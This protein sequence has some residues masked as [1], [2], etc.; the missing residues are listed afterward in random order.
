MPQPEP[1]GLRSRANHSGRVQT[2][3]SLGTASPPP[4]APCSAYGTYILFLISLAA[5]IWLSCPVGDPLSHRLVGDSQRDFWGFLLYKFLFSNFH[6]WTLASPAAPNCDLCCLISAGTQRSTV[7]PTFYN[8]VGKLFWDR[9]LGNCETYL[10]ATIAVCCSLS[11]SS[12]A[13]YLI[14]VHCQRASLI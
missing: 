13:M 1:S 5:A 4:P 10:L 6:L 2:P 3:K 11:E 8:V 9:N 14:A 7:I 12:C